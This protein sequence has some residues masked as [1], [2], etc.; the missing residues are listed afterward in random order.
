MEQLL[1][2]PPSKRGGKRKGAGRKAIVP[3]RQAHEERDVHK[4]AN[5][6]HVVLRVLKD[7]PRL[8]NRHIYHALRAAFAAASRETFRLV[9]YSVQGNHLHLIVEAEDKVA[10]SRGMQGLA[11]RVARGVNKKVGRKGKVFFDRYFPQYMKFPQQVRR[12]LIYVL[13]NYLHHPNER[14]FGPVDPFS[15]AA[16]FDGWREEPPVSDDARVCVPART[17]LLTTGWQRGGKIGFAEAPA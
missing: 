16:H 15:S 9:Q 7:V 1:L 13:N 3:G 14:V 12:G 11:I 10:L 6:V 2:L 17:W 4:R 5:P 8:R